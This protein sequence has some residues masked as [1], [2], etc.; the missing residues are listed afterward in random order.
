MPTAR[1][2]CDDYCCQFR[3]T[4]IA[5][6][7]LHIG[8]IP[9]IGAV[10]LL[11]TLLSTVE[12]L[13]IARGIVV[14]IQRRHALIRIIQTVFT[15]SFGRLVCSRPWDRG[16]L[17]VLQVFSAGTVAAPVFGFEFAVTDLTL[18]PLRHNLLCA[19]VWVTV[20]CT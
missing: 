13:I 15:T 16:V 14:W 7:T 1:E 4:F 19:V 12:A 9:R 5:I 18:S 17:H 3:L 20:K 11:V 8:R 6:A 10:R 2:S